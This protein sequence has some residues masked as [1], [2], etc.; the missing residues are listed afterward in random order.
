[1]VQ[2]EARIHTGAMDCGRS[3][4]PSPGMPELRSVDSDASEFQAAAISPDLAWRQNPRL[5]PFLFPTL[6]H[7]LKR[8]LTPADLDRPAPLR[9]NCRAVLS[10]NG[11][12]MDARRSPG[13]VRCLSFRETGTGDAHASYLPTAK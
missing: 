7:T 1:M 9:P 2:G 13:V 11:K 6:H 12:I 4:S 8:R 3:A 10:S 5:V